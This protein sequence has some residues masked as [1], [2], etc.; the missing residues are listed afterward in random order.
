MAYSWIEMTIN[1]KEFLNINLLHVRN[2]TI[3]CL[4]HFGWYQNLKILAAVI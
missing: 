3:G 2:N 1:L 4:Q